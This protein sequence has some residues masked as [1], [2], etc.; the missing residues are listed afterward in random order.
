[1]KR[2]EERTLRGTLNGKPL[3]IYGDVEC[4]VGGSDRYH[5]Q[6]QR[7]SIDRQRRKQHRRQI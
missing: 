6:Q 1:M 2:V 7:Y 3:N 4:A 5:S